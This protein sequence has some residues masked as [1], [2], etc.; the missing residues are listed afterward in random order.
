MLIVGFC[1]VW[2]MQYK[3][4]TQSAINHKQTEPGLTVMIQINTFN[5]LM[6]GNGTSQ[7]PLFDE[8]FTVAALPH[9]EPDRDC[10]TGTSSHNTAGY[11]YY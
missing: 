6:A 11:R 1:A 9:S 7:L 5:G 3:P 8:V 4:A 10:V 2:I